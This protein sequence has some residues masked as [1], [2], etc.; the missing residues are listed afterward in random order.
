MLYAA[1][2]GRYPFKRV[3]D[4]QA[5]EGQQ[6]HLMLQVRQD[7]GGALGEGP[8]GGPPAHWPGSPPAAWAVGGKKPW[9]AAGWC[10][11]KYVGVACGWLGL[12]RPCLARGG[13]LAPTCCSP[14][15]LSP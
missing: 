3:E 10:A 13:R 7:G 14:A 6:L 12:L 2:T 15:K 9:G 1:V 8:W 5:P 4:A 11:W